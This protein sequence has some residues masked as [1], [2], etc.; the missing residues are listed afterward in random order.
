MPGFSKKHKKKI[1]EAEAAKSGTAVA[2]RPSPAAAGPSTTPA[3]P[4]PPKPPKYYVDNYQG[5]PTLHPPQARDAPHPIDRFWPIGYTC[6]ALEDWACS[7]NASTL[8]NFSI[9]MSEEAVIIDAHD[10]GKGW[11]LVQVWCPRTNMQAVVPR[12]LVYISRETRHGN[13]KLRTNFRNVIPAIAGLP[14]ATFDPVAKAI[15]SFLRELKNTEESLDGQVHPD[16]FDLLGKDGS[17]IDKYVLMM[18]KGM[19]DSGLLPLINKR[20]LNYSELYNLTPYTRHSHPDNGVAICYMFLYSKFERNSKDPMNRAIARDEVHIRIGETWQP[21]SRMRAHI[22]SIDAE[23]STHRHYKVAKKASNRPCVELARFPHGTPETELLIFEQILQLLFGST[24]SCFWDDNYLTRYATLLPETKDTPASKKAT[25]FDCEAV[26]VAAARAVKL[27]AEAAWKPAAG[28]WVPMIDRATFHGSKSIVVHGLDYATPLQALQGDNRKIM[29]DIS[30]N[31]FGVAGNIKTIQVIEPFKLWRKNDFLMIGTFSSHGKYKGDKRIEFNIPPG[32]EIKGLREGSLVT[33]TFEIMMDGAHHPKSYARLCKFSSI[34]DWSDA[35]SWAARANWIDD[36]GKERQFYLQVVQHANVPETENEAKHP[37]N[38]AYTK[39]LAFRRALLGQTA[40]EAIRAKYD[41]NIRPIR[42][43][44]V[45]LN[46]YAQELTIGPMLR[47]SGIATPRTQK[48]LATLVREMKSARTPG[49]TPVFDNVNVP[50][51]PDMYKSVARAAGGKPR[52]SCDRCALNNEKTVFGV[53]GR[54]RAGHCKPVEGQ[55]HRCEPCFAA[56][57]PCS[58]SVIPTA[59]A[60]DDLLSGKNV[61]NS[62]AMM[63]FKIQVEWL[64]AT[65]FDDEIYETAR[66]IPKNVEEGT[67][68]GAIRTAADT[69]KS[70]QQA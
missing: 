13:Y 22:N 12:A 37:I 52:T 11:E 60:R 15:Q 23:K 26:L 19:K 3:V 28:N 44:K 47:P 63:K 70:P 53:K 49:G 45:D 66:N 48:D 8:A 24:V 9:K 68:L 38:V 21:T 42:A 5:P 1:A 27:V 20:D 67:L 64:L 30:P 51:T 7:K 2:L 17:N 41:L 31:M 58:V 6:F 32:A 25:I 50:R 16:I 43:C 56:G 69:G 40:P 62:N 18:H 34:S 29:Y 39:G 61:D 46:F 35:N 57:L 54:L 33:L 59:Q 65:V 36:Q 10:R 4:P 55:P 14:S